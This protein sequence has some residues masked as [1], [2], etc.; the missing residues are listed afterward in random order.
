MSAVGRE[1]LC[2]HPP[3]TGLPASPAGGCASSSHSFV[4]FH[5]NSSF[6]AS[7]SVPGC[8]FLPH[9]FPSS[10]HAH[11]PF[12]GGGHR[13]PG[14]PR[15]CH[16]PRQ[17]EPTG[18]CER[19]MRPGAARDGGHRP[20]KAAQQSTAAVGGRGGARRLPRRAALWDARSRPPLRASVLFCFKW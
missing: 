12:P 14:N 19:A 15:A 5:T 16:T 6:P 7:L 2:H 13:S 8:L 9:T 20:L 4:H 17:A 3:S 10:S 1:L 18:P 11:S